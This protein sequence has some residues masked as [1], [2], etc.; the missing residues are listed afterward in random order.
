MEVT[1]LFDHFTKLYRPYIKIAQ[2]LLDKYELHP[3]Q[4]LILKDIYHH[5]QTTLVQ[6]SKRRSIEKPTT[7]KILKVLDERQWLVIQPGQ[8]KRE[9]LLTL[10]QEGEHIYHTLM[11]DIRKEQA[12]ITATLDITPDDLEQT[13]QL[14]DQ[15]YKNMIAKIQCLESENK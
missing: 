8:D 7:R 5:P 12:T 9:K 1:A 4:W 11:A 14:L 13:I 3:A 6:I 2:P 10:S 15:L